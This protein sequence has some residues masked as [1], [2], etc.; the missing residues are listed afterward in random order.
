[1]ST[2]QKEES[3]YENMRQLY[4]ALTIILFIPAT[5]II[6]AFLLDDYI[7]A[8]Y[9]ISILYRLGIGCIYIM[10]VTLATAKIYDFFGVGKDIV[11][12][13]EDEEEK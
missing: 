11:S 3:L 1:M 7:V 4:R 5:I 2:E 12:L 9:N 13:V 10:L 8:R 6:G